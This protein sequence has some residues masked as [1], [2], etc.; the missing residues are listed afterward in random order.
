MWVW[1]WHCG[2]AYKRGEFKWSEPLEA[3]RDEREL[4][5]RLKFFKWVVRSFGVVPDSEP[6]EMCPYEDCD[7]VA[8]EHDRT[9]WEVVREHHPEY[10]VVPERG[11]VYR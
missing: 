5:R 9:D 8:D 10:P 3:A 4:M 7:G 1:C 11:V 6:Y 2:R